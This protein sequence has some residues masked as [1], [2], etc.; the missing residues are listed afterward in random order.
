MEPKE[1]YWSRHIERWESSG[2]TQQAYCDR[3]DLSVSTFRL[4]RR[5]LAESDGEACLD[6]VPLVQVSRVVPS[7]APLTLLVEGGRY[8]VEVADEVRGETLRTVLDILEAR[9]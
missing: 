2:L 8:R 1:R 9:R 3:H 7:R 5:Q 6:I 4:W